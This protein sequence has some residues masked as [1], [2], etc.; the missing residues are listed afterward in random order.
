V[1]ISMTEDIERRLL[2]LEHIV[3]DDQEGDDE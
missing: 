2:G 3:F 1:L